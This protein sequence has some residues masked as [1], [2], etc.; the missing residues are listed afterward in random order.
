MGQYYARAT[1]VIT[2]LGIGTELELVAMA[3]I[4]QVDINNA[5]P[6]EHKEPMTLNQLRGYRSIIANSYFERL[7]IVQEMARAKETLVMLGA[8]TL[9][10]VT[11]SWRHFNWAF[12]QLVF[13]RIITS[14]TSQAAQQ[15]SALRQEIRNRS[16]IL[17]RLLEMKKRQNS[18]DIFELIEAFSKLDY[19]DP[20]DKLYALRDTGHLQQ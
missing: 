2:W 9:T 7:W 3:R 18:T 8:E 5:P 17:F 15:E 4:K 1:K 20:R 16:R 10:P 13:E 11:T 19:A 14:E 12:V 6:A